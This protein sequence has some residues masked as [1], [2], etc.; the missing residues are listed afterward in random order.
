MVAHSASPDGYA[1]FE[2]PRVSVAG[3]GTLAAIHETSH[4]TIV[5][6]PSGAAFAEIGADPEA[7][8]SEAA[9]VGS[10][11]RLLVLSR[12]AAHSTVHLLDPY[13]PRTIAEIRLE[14]PMRLVA[15][16][17]NAALVIGSL[18]AAVLAAT[19]NHLMPYPFPTRTVPLAAGAAAGQFVVALAGTIEEWD[20]QSRTPR[21]RLR[22]PRSA[23]ITAVGGSERVVWMT[24]Q[25]E[26]ARIDVIPLV[27]RG[28]RRAHDLPEP[29]ARIVGHPRSDLVACI[30]AD[31]GRLYVIDLDGRV[32][33]RV[34]DPEGFD[35][36]E[37]VGLVIGRMIGVLAAQAERP[38]AIIPLNAR[39]SD[40]D[41]ASTPAGVLPRSEPVSRPG[42]DA[43]S[44]DEPA[45]V[46]EVAPEPPEPAPAPP[47]SPAAS[48][49][50]VPPPT[51]SPLSASSAS[52]TS[53]ASPGRPAPPT[54]MT[55]LFRQPPIAPVPPPSAPD[56]RGPSSVGERFSAWRDLV[57]R[58]QPRE[59]IDA[60]LPFARPADP[61]VGHPAGQPVQHPADH[62]VQ[63]TV[64]DPVQHPADQLARQPVDHLARQP[65]DHP[66]QHP[67]D[68][69][70]PVDHPARHDEPQAAGSPVN[71]RA[72]SEP[73]LS[74]RDEVVAWSR[75]V[76][77]GTLHGAP[78]V[79]AIDAVLARF[80]LA[81]ALQPA[82]VLLYG[83]HLCGERGA[84][85]V[86]V[87]RV[88]DRQW[89]EALGRGELARRGVAVHTGSR[90]ALAP[91]VLRVLDELPPVT[92]SL[93][94]EPGTVTLLGPC[95]VVAEPDEPLA[96]VAERCLGRAGS[97]ILAARG[98]PERA[99]L[100]LEARACGAAPML[101]PEP[102]L[103][104]APADAAIFVIADGE[105]ADRLGLPRLA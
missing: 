36:V 50:P 44:R 22:L 3:D 35:R 77:A 37:S 90:V 23:A 74:W 21:R 60:P 2:Q 102:A 45:P 7:L 105:L 98:A 40:G 9:W 24:T 63:P 30:G 93:I 55:A 4:V 17:G 56:A 70:H 104:A 48:A 67:V 71:E 92:G 91:A 27:N 53:S 51:P 89:G 68:H 95:V 6:I 54:A 103:D 83:A 26:P 58:N 88:L 11:P 16:V 38:I 69:R 31:S 1:P 86:D 64:A 5:E 10:P 79:P 82:L 65:V 47:P 20:P 96:A 59:P 28:Q 75:A 39:D 8:A 61:S 19:E 72:A 43:G 52:S 94:G 29:I 80:E 85:P 97:A 62:P 66:A 87:S 57:R 101:R 25:Q 33:Q 42:F 73:P 15:T 81:P 46:P 18:G 32:R 100:V 76:I 13:G 84:A 78:S 12:Y 41:A 49:P 99:E 34:I 14:A